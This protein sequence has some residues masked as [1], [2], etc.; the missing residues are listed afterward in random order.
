M[1]GTDGPIP[2]NRDAPGRNAG[3]GSRTMFP[4]PS[5]S[6]RAL[7]PSDCLQLRPAGGTGGG[8]PSKV[9]WEKNHSDEQQ[10]IKPR[11]THLQ[12]THF[13]PASNKPTNQQTTDEKSFQMV[14]D[15]LGLHLSEVNQFIILCLCACADR[16]F[17]SLRFTMS[18]PSRGSFVPFPRSSLAAFRLIVACQVMKGLLLCGLW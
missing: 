11:S 4:T 3:T 16:L 18:G 5:A 8:D 17:H 14:V 1:Q 2:S 9:F 12:A 6:H 15:A 13:S 7:R 10:K